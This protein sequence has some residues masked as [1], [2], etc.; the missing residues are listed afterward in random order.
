MADYSLSLDLGK[1]AKQVRRIIMETPAL[2]F[3]GIVLMPVAITIVWKL[4]DIITALSA[5]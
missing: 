3:W 5:I 1:A 2:R 4:P